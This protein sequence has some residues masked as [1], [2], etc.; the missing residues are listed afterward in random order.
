MLFIVSSP[1]FFFFFARITVKLCI[2]YFVLGGGVGRA[3]IHTDEMIAKR[4]MWLNMA[5]FFP[6]IIERLGCC[7]WDASDKYHFLPF[8]RV[9]WIQLLR[10]FWWN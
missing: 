7:T 8:Q 5:D 4:F 10:P 3:A 2:F 1:I 6:F 9:N